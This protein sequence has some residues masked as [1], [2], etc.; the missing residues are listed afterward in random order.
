MN[1]PTNNDI[2]YTAAPG[3]VQTDRILDHIFPL[4]KAHS[5]KTGNTGG[6]ELIGTAFT[7]GPR[8]YAL[9]A[10]HVIDQCFNDL[11]ENEQVVAIFWTSPS[12]YIL[13]PISAHERHLTEDVGIIKLLP[14]DLHSFFEVSESH[15]NASCEYMCWG[16]PHETADEIKKLDKDAHAQPELI[17]TQGYIRRRITR[18][19]YPIMIFRGTQFYEL[20]EQVGGGNSGGPVFNKKASAHQ[21]LWKVMG[22]YIGEKEGGQVS[23]AV[24]SEAFASWRPTLLGGKTIREHSLEQAQ[25]GY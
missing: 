4:A 5:S 6:F 23:Y 20:S 15:E 13:F 16:Y 21:K 25:G 8:G 17:Y 2:K 9:T 10:A 19:L 24:R 1:N 7:I 22:I 11:K 18:E 12:S 3:F 14:D